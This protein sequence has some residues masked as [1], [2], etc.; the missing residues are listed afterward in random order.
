MLDEGKKN[1]I[2]ATS[3][4]YLDKP[5]KGQEEGYTLFSQVCCLSFEKHIPKK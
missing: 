5:N 2:L 4:I 3:E 1:V